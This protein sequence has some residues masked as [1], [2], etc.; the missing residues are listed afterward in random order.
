[1]AKTGIS[2]TEQPPSYLDERRSFARAFG[3]FWGALFCVALIGYAALLLIGRTE[4]FRDLVG[5]RMEASL[6][7]P[8]SIGN[9]RITP[10]LAIQ[11]E[12]VRGGASATN[13]A[14]ALEAERVVMRI[15]P[16]GFLRG[17]A[18][19]LRS[20]SI[21]NAAFRFVADGDSQWRPLPA[22][23]GELHRWVVV[24]GRSVDERDAAFP[25]LVWFRENEVELRLDDADFFWRDGGGAV[26]AWMEDVTVEAKA[27]KPFEQAALWSRLQAGEV[28]SVWN[29]TVEG[30]QVEWIGT[31]EGYVVLKLMRD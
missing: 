22:L 1:M 24:A 2:E 30:L 13:D 5:D 31:A 8:V 21:D 20:L 16:G 27:M 15:R 18:W 12:Q 10:A 7:V 17:R 23:A 19:P 3:R 14:P 25:G 11:L 6:G 4:G 29:D 26:S 28:G 9:S